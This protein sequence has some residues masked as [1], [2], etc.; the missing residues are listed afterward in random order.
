MFYAQSTSTVISWRHT[1]VDQQ[2]DRDGD[3][4]TE[5]WRKRD[6]QTD[7]K[8]ARETL[9]DRRTQTGRQTKTVRQ[10]KRTIWDEAD[11]ETWSAETE[12]LLTAR[13]KPL[14]TSPR[15]VLSSG[16]VPR[17]QKP[18]C[19]SVENPGLSNVPTS[20]P[21]VGQNIAGNASP[22]ARMFVYFI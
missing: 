1:E 16:R 20:K 5:A 15:A 2:A 17:T 8:I 11:R 6:R 12:L 18:K 9:G 22:T 21:G 7:R 19:P 14:A 4:E 10:R 13:F 3:R